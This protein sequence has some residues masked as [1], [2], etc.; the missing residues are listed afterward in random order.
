MRLYTLFPTTRGFSNKTIDYHGEDL[1]IAA[2]SIR[3][4]YAFAHNDT[5]ATSSKQPRGIVATYEREGHRDGW[6]LLWCGCRVFDVGFQHGMTSTAIMRV[7][8]RHE[9]AC[10]AIA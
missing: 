7:M 5:W 4:A 2:E 6:Y 10:E 8:A 9:A 1:M 3:Q